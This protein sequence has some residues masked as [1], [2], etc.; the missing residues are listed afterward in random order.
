[1]LSKPVAIAAVAL[2]TLALT[3]CAPDGGDTPGTSTTPSASQGP[4][5]PPAPAAT[6][7][8][9]DGFDATPVT[10]ECSALVTPQAVYDYNPN[11]SLQP[12]FTPVA[13]SDVATIMD[14]KG[15]GCSWVNQTSG[16]TFVVAAAQLAA[17]DIESIKQ[18]LSSSSTPVTGVGDSAFFTASG[19]VGVAE[20]FS[21][22]YWIVA[23][24]PAFYEIAEAKPLLQAALSALGR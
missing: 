20:V 18:V 15:V 14:N 4:T 9:G 10:V 21:G 17:A 8:P 23:T 12:S 3:G 7:Q 16:E 19:G 13:G 22:S 2:L 5:D 24:S 1:M 11:Y 6:D